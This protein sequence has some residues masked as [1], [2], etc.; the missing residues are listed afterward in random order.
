M[1]KFK[2]KA[3][4]LAEVLITLAIIGVVAA[5]TIPVLMNNVQDAQLKTAWKKEYSVISQAYSSLV[6]DNGGN[7][8]GL[9]N[10]PASLISVLSPYLRIIKTC[11]SSAA[12]GCWSPA[13]TLKNSAGT[14]TTGMPTNAGD[15]SFSTAGIV[16]QDGTYVLF[17]QYTGYSC[18]LSV[19]T[20]NLYNTCGYALIDVNGSKPPTQIGKDVYLIFFTDVKVLPAGH[21][22]SLFPFGS[23]GTYGWGWSASN[24]VN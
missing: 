14:A 3:F 15:T 5:I 22:G 21:S 17:Q 13:G 10:S 16:L 12:E 24:L 2:Q 23:N 20:G 6:T 4:T 19:Y 11:A 9:F 18:P 7:A 8:E 1:H